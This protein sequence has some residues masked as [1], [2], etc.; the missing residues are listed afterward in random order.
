M[1]KFGAEMA[2]GCTKRVSTFPP[3]L[4]IFGKAEMTCVPAY[5]H[6]RGILSDFIFVFEDDLGRENHLIRRRN[7]LDRN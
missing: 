3:P 2:R 4:F 5:E 1:D 7:Y 6:A